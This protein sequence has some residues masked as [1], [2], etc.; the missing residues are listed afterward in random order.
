MALSGDG[1][2]EFF[3]GYN[4]YL[5]LP[6]INQYFGN[7]PLN[8][9]KILSYFLRHYPISKKGL[10]V[11]KLQKLNSSIL[12]VGKLD[13]IYNS[14]KMIQNYSEKEFCNFNINF[15]ENEEINFFE[16]TEE[17]LMMADILTYLHSDILVKLDRASMFS[18][19][20]TRAPFLD[21]RI[22]ELAWS[23]P[24]SLKIKNIKSKKIGKIAL[25][26]ILSKYIPD[27]LLDRPK[28][29]FTM[30]TGP[31]LKG[32]LKNWAKD[33]LSHESIKSQ[34]FINPDI[35]ENMLEKHLKGEEDNT[36]RLW[37]I[38]MWQAWLNEWY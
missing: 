36:S 30:P 3:G 23:M 14:V 31:W 29:G 21:N 5:L 17:S 2:D 11:D 32:P 28:Q 19:L 27:K 33:L 25:R 22:A 8:I 26:R 9:R 4:R 37:N 20:E 15:E 38:L 7:L 24:L 12:N 10:R 1:A 35:V 6:K 34:G 18:S 16:S 13:K